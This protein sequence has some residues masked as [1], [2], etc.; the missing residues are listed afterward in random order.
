LHDYTDEEIEEY[1]EQAYK[2][3]SL[4]KKQI[5]ENPEAILKM[6]PHTARFVVVSEDTAEDHSENSEK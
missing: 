5:R 3:L 4:L 2:E 1:A 6:N